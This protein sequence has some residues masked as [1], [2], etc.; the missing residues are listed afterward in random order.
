MRPDQQPLPSYIPRCISGTLAADPP[1]A[2]GF[3]AGR[4]DDLDFV[5]RGNKRKQLLAGVS[6]QQFGRVRVDYQ[7]G[8]NPVGR[9]IDNRHLTMILSRV[10]ATIP[11]I[12]QIP[13]GIERD[14]VGAA[15]QLEAIQQ[16]I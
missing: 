15:I 11:H 13:S 1:L 3:S 14:A 5:F 9:G 7:R 10:L 4:V 6:E 8:D 12:Q 16:A 2:S